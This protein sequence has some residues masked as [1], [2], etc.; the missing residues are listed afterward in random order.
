MNSTH[1]LALL[2]SSEIKHLQADMAAASVAY[3]EKYEQFV[4]ITEVTRHIPSEL[5]SFFAER[6]TYY[7]ELSK[8]IG[9]LDTTIDE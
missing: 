6:L 5:Q 4:N 3:N 9:R 2:N 8:K 7:R 1:N